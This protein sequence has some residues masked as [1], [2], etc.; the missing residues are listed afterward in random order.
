M[1]YRWLLS[2]FASLP[3][4][5]S[6]A[7]A[8]TTAPVEVVVVT[9]RVPGPPLWRVVN[10]DREL[11]IFPALS[12]VPEGII[13]DASRIEVVLAE[14]QEVILAPDID[15]DF[16]LTV[17]LNP[18]NLIRG[19]RLLRR[20]AR[21]PDDQTLEDVLPPELFQRYEAL[22]RAYFPRDDKP[23]RSRPLFAGTSLVERIQR[24]EGLVS[25]DEVMKQVERLI[26][27]NRDLEQTTIEV[28]MDL[29]GSFRDVAE[30]AEILVESLAPEQELA[31]FAE[32]LRRGESELDAMKNRANAWA[33]GYID[34]FRGIPL[35]GD[36]DDACLLLL[37]ESSEFETIEE[38]RAELD[39]LWLEAAERAL[40]SNA[41]TFAILDIVELLRE[42]GLLARL[43]AQGYE[44]RAP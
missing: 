14:S 24:E 25:G 40:S 4:A 37:N 20:L 33:Q 39:R 21:N 5:A 42:D 27:R 15:A 29:K 41:S 36:D 2:A 9:G 11:Y 18:I 3:L 17:M 12:P 19:A 43:E 8:Q 32:Q 30:R 34:E 38:L 35:P 13:W 22:R 44:V 23:E 1:Q 31:C 6:P 26:R 7:I 28:V 10:G 16:S